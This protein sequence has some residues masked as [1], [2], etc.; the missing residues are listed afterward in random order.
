MT[1]PG[2][3]NTVEKTSGDENTYT[4]EN[5]GVCILI[6][7]CFDLTTW[8]YDSE[9]ELKQSFCFAINQ[10]WIFNNVDNPWTCLICVIT[11]SI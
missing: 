4:C 2:I 8:L 5:T 7:T 9:I 1:S 3:V 6:S 10:N 11:G